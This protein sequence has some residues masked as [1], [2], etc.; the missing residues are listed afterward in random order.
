MIEPY[1]II[2]NSMKRILLFAAAGLIGLAACT[3]LDSPK[4]RAEE[5]ALIITVNNGAAIQT[6][7][8]DVSP[9]GK[10]ADIHDIQLFL[11]AA[12]GSL[13]RR[14]EL[15]SQEMT[16]SL[17]RVKT[18]TY[19]IVAVAN[20]PALADIRTKT[21]LEQTTIN[22]GLNQVD[23]GFLMYGQTASPVSV[24]SGATTAAR[25][26]ITVRRHVGRV[27]LTTVQNGI[28]VAYGALKVSYAFLENGLG[29]WNLAG[30]GD[31]TDYVNYAGRKKGKNASASAVD[32]VAAAADADYAAL[33]F[34]ALN[35]TLAGGS[36]ETFN[37]PFYTF[38]NKHTAADDH[39]DGA[40]SGTV[41]ARLV[42]KAS[43][44]E[45]DAQ[46]WYY[47]VTIE[48]L[49]RNKTYDV[50]FIIRGPGADDPNKKV[51]SGNLEVVIQV[52]PWGDGGEIK[53][54]F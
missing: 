54:D 39:F 21:A 11:F 13:Y 48:N 45:G 53:G 20:A 1:L 41:C 32:F 51:E 35:R 23:A 37:V 49:E 40:T 19:D 52:D 25:A 36:T 17:D 2:H 31:P 38:P 9:V 42:L 8:A 7:A 12:D 33:T 3:E 24:T 4:N 18:G 46:S 10:D 27:R 34:Q 44:G 22:L 43:Y 5:G 30:S 29:T 6:K 47:P 16:K 15:S 28:P 26:E 14:E 50:S